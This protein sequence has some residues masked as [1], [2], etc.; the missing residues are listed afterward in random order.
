MAG[1]EEKPEKIKKNKKEKQGRKAKSKMSLAKKIIIALLGIILI[2]AII[3][4]ILVYFA[5]TILGKIGFE[6]LDESQLSLNDVYS[7][8]SDQVSKQEFDSIKNIALLGIDGG[9]SDSMI[10]AS[11][12]QTDHT[13][14]LISIPRDTYVKV[15][16]YGK[17]KINHAYAY[18]KE[19]LALRTINENFGLNISEYI[20]INF[21]GLINIINKIGGIELN[22]TKEEMNY[23]NNNSANSYSLTKK[24][25][26]KV[27]TYGK[28]TLTGEQALTHA[29]NRTVG[30]DFVREERQRTV[31]TAVI[32][33]VSKLGLAEIL[34]LSDS[35]LSEVKTNLNIA[36]WTG[37]LTG[38]L[39][40]KNEYLSNIISKQIPSDEKGNGSGRGQMINEIYYFVVD[41][42]EASRAFKNT[43]YGE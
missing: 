31:I 6:R 19:T 12:N 2:F 4:G 13:I 43:I 32:E 26:K 5:S 35:I 39:G 16:G 40:Y 30:N 3:F 17:T 14:K 10:I 27:T 37:I 1:K 33:K 9:R 34:G 23:I 7:E 8:V 22:I 28:V 21:K 29:R 11:V 42:E 15:E 25:V 41:L 18:G 38:A 36:E 20:T 24:P